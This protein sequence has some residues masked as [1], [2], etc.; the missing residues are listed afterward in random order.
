MHTVFITVSGP[1]LLPDNMVI[2]YV[3]GVL[4]IKGRFLD[5]G[6]QEYGSKKAPTFPLVLPNTPEVIHPVEGVI[7]QTLGGIESH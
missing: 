6:I 1:Q 2:V 5:P 3:P 7:V 4:N